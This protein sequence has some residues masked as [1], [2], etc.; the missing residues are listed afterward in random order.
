VLRLRILGFLLAFEGGGLIKEGEDGSEV[1]VSR[2]GRR[3]SARLLG[4]LGFLGEGEVIGRST[5]SCGGLSNSPIFRL[6]KESNPNDDPVNDDSGMRVIGDS[7]DELGD[8]SDN[9]DESTVDI[10]VVGE[11]SV[12]SEACVEVLSRC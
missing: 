6:W 7:G 5:V 1:N 4:F 2:V 3:L 10:V 12:E 9:E 11:E 8:G